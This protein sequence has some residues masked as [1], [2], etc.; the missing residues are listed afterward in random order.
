MDEAALTLGGGG[1]T[2]SCGG[3]MGGLGDAVR[4]GAA[5]NACGGAVPTLAVGAF[6]LARLEGFRGGAGGAEGL[7]GALEMN[8]WYTSTNLVRD[9]GLWNFSR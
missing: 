4:M 6:G 9:D 1:A 7:T 2:I 3:V 8:R 5:G